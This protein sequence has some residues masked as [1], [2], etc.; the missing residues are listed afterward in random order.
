MATTSS[1]A[2][3]SASTVPPAA[4]TLSS[5]TSNLDWGSKG[6]T[7]LL[8]VQNYSWD[9]F[10]LCFNSL[11]QLVLIVCCVGILLARLSFGKLVI[12]L[13]IKL[14][15]LLGFTIIFVRMLT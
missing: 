12:L 3:G 6:W 11:I 10:S 5:S 2:S 9:I 1:A 4:S 7:L 15:S 14:R 13:G 8:S